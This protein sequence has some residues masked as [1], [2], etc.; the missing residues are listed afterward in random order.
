MAKETHKTTTKHFNIFKEEC[1]KWIEIFH[2]TRWE[3]NFFHEESD[4]SLAAIKCN[5]SAKAI[6]IIFNKTWNWTKPP[7]E[8]EIKKCGFHEACEVL[9]Y[10]LRYLGECRFLSESEID[11]ATHE[12]IHILE[13]V[14]WENL[15]D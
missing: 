5:F 7:D 6:D 11:P 3:I 14:V 4:D 2:L 1:L 8:H 9:L 12:I 13:N 15:V 10:P